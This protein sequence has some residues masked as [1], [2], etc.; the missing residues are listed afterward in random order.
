MWPVASIRRPAARRGS[1]APAPAPAPA[2]ST[3]RALV[4]EA[5]DDPVQWAAQ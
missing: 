4:R 5:P 1:V 2:P 3:A